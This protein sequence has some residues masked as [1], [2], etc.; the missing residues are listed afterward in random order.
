MK[1]VKFP[2]LL[3]ARALTALMIRKTLGVGNEPSEIYGE[4]RGMVPR[5]GTRLYQQ[6]PPLKIIV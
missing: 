5:E 4:E 6:F 2:L 1:T 3:L